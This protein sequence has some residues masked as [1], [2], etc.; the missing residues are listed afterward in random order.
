MAYTVD[1]IKVLVSLFDYTTTTITAEASGKPTFDLLEEAFQD[2][3]RSASCVAI[4]QSIREKT[5]RNL[6]SSDFRITLCELLEIKWIPE[7][8]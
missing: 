4:H 2:Y 3:G 7:R 8:Q 6:D 1:L 5:Q